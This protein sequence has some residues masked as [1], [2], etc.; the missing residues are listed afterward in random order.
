M[1][2]SSINSPTKEN[3]FSS[4]GIFRSKNDSNKLSNNMKNNEA[5]S[6]SENKNTSSESTITRCHSINRCMSHSSASEF[7]D[8][9]SLQFTS[10]SCPASRLTLDSLSDDEEDE[11]NIP[12]LSQS[13]IYRIGSVTSLSS[14]MSSNSTSS[15]VSSIC[16]ARPIS[17][18]DSMM[19]NSIANSTYESVTSTIAFNIEEIHYVHRQQTQALDWSN[20]ICQIEEFKG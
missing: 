8:N 14:E 7:S 15:H 20:S 11:E 13:C 16:M 1:K 12:E 18:F 17:S 19:E 3:L 5:N 9:A 10:T 4:D 2:V 6:T